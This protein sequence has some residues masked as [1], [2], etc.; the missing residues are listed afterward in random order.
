[1]WANVGAGLPAMAVG[2]LIH[3]ATDTP[4]SQASQLPQLISI[5]CS[6]VAQ[7]IRPR[8]LALAT[9]WVRRSTPNLL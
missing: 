4:P 5:A 6:T 2:Q 9:A 8:L 1:M 7:A 3:P